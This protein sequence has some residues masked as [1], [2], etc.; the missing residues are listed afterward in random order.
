MRIISLLRREVI[1]QLCV[2]GKVRSQSKLCR[3]L[4]PSSTS[5]F[6]C[7]LY[8]ADKIGLDTDSFEKLRTSTWVS[9]IAEI[10]VFDKERHNKVYKYMRIYLWSALTF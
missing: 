10:L 9:L 1:S 4:L 3:K 6:Q 8:E 5:H 2:L 7:N